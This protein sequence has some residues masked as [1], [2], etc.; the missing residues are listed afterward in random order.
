MANTITD[1][2]AASGAVAADGRY[3]SQSDVE[4]R[5]GE[6]NVAE[7]SN[8]NPDATEA[9]TDRI[10][11]AIAHAED[12]VD[13]RFRNSRYAV[14]LVAVSGTLYQV[15]DWCAKLAG[16]WLYEHRGISDD[17]AEGGKLGDL[18]EKVEQEIDGVL[19]GSVDLNAQLNHDDAPS[20]P[21][22]V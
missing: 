7:W 5:F 18:A 8:L 21:V 11:N 6:D 14:P 2:S 20:A 22:C 10:E 16:L 1:G 9:D 19:S 4:D 13:N 12:H 3:I 17:D 15:H